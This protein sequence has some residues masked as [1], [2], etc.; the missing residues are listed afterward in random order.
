MDWQVR[1]TQ[2]RRAVQKT[3]KHEQNMHQSG[4]RTHDYPPRLARPPPPPSKPA[5][6][7]HRGQCALTFCARR[8]GRGTSF[9]GLAAASNLRDAASLALQNRPVRFMLVTQMLRERCA[10]LAGDALQERELREELHLWVAVVQALTTLPHAPK[11]E[12]SRIS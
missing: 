8:R 5:G 3:T 4:Q 12:A 9:R 7:A 6:P 1:P 2:G 10:A 11:K